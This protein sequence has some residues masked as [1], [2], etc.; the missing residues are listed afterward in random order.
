M[1]SS[2]SLATH[3][4]QNQKATKEKVTLYGNIGKG[5]VEKRGERRIASVRVR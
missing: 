2:K 3:S 1:G 5:S 4:G